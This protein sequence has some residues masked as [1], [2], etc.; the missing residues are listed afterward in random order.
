MLDIEEFMTLSEVEMAEPCPAFLAAV[1]LVVKLFQE[2]A[3]E[4]DFLEL[5][6]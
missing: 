1:A 4:E 5:D 6:C 2:R 3:E